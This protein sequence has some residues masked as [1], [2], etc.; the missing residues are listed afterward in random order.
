MCTFIGVECLAAN[1]LIEL[2]EKQ[3]RRLSFKQLADYGLMVVDAYEDETSEKAIF[4]FNQ[5]KIQGLILD[6]SNYFSVE[7]ID[8]EKYICL[9]EDV[10][11]IELKERFRWTLSYELLKAV[12]RVQISDG[13]V[14][15]KF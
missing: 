3:I 11:I 15:I 14:C 6:Y 10:N 9:N 7:I 8:E 5:E 12:N 4:I 13:Y 2:Y 1:A